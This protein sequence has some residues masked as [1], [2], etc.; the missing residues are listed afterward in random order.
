MTARPGRMK[1]ELPIDLPHPRDP[2][3]D[4]FRTL[5]RRIYADLDEELAKSFRMEGRDSGG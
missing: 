1:T 2:T 5:E 4:P 3:S